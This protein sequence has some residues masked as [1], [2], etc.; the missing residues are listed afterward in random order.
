MAEFA[1]HGVS[2]RTTKANHSKKTYSR[3]KAAANGSE[4]RAT[5]GPI[6][7]LIR[8]LI[9][10]AQDSS[11]D[12]EQRGRRKIDRGTQRLEGRQEAEVPKVR[13]HTAHCWQTKDNGRRRRRFCGRDE[14]V[15]GIGE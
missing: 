7:A 1:W 15:K 11:V 12:E 6:D 10:T 9:V 2:A 14:E 3:G 4:A 13:G 5:R 8:I